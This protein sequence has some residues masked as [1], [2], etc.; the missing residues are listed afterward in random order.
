MSD[1][2]QTLRE[3]LFPNMSEMNRF[4]QVFVNVVLATDIFDK[5]LNDLRK[6]RWTRAFASSSDLVDTNH[7]DYQNLRAT[8]VI[9]HIMQASDVS[10]TMQHWH[11]YRK[12]NEKLFRECYK[13]FR[14]GRAEKDPT[15]FWY[16]GEK[17]FYDYY[18]IPLAKKL[19]EC[20]VFGVSSSEYLDYALKNRAE[21]EIHGQ[22]A[23]Q[24]MVANVKNQE[25]LLEEKGARDFSC[26]P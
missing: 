23:V 1:Q 9:E 14:E 24:E 8:I 13:A 15:T 5:Q 19:K 7:D 10:H 12:W 20:G 25:K 16:E 18:I 2:F 17:G 6:S 3:F 22:E 11:I 4:R 26:V 21:W